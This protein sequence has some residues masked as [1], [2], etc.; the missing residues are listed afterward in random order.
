MTRS[1]LIDL[2]FREISAKNGYF[3]PRSMAARSKNPGLLKVPKT[4]IN[5]FGVTEFPSADAGETALK[6]FISVSISFNR[7]FVELLGV[8][9]ATLVLKTLKN[10]HSLLV[11]PETIIKDF[12]ENV[13]FHRAFNRDN[14][15][16]RVSN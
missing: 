4:D 1:A 15:G 12:L 13:E 6:K 11:K 16:S 3:N 14:Q 2:L 10:H 5:E 7:S 8:Q 9:K